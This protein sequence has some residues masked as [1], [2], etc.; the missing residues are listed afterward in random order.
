MLTRRELLRQ[1]P[2]ALLAMACG[3]TAGTDTS[4]AAPRA[5]VT[6]TTGSPPVPSTTSP[7]TSAPPSTTTPDTRSFVLRSRQAWGARP[8]VE[9]LLL[10]RSGAMRYL[11]V[12]HAG[13]TLGITGPERFRSW[14]GWHMDERGW[15]DLAY[16]YIIG[17]D[18]VVW[19]GR[20]VGLRGDTATSYDPDRHFLVVVEGNFDVVEPTP[21]QLRTLPLVLAWAAATWEVPTASIAGHKDYAATACPGANLYSY[22]RSGALRADVEAVLAAGGAGAR[23]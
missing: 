10:P 3:G 5:P 19:T 7:T 22:L 13:D 4:S 21:A 20:D 14:Q 9:S 18:G 15:G 17:V 11:T 6:A 16:H 23:A 12:H 1:L 2:L 8:P